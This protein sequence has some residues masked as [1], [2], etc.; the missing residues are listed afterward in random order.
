MRLALLPL[1]WMDISKSKSLF[2]TIGTSTMTLTYLDQNMSPAN[3][4]FVV[5]HL[6]AAA[7]SCPLLSCSIA[8]PLET[9]NT[10]CHLK[11]VYAQPNKA[12]WPVIR[13]SFLNLAGSAS[14]GEPKFKLTLCHI[15]VLEWLQYSCW[16]VYPSRLRFRRK[17]E[18]IDHLSWTILY[19]FPQN[20]DYD[21]SCFFGDQIQ[22]HL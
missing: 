1:H 19:L 12:F 4:F 16:N 14:N 22:V 15:K 20:V 5:Y 9:C 10:S 6:S 8:S 18:W 17:K 3:K 21:S 13:T 11:L 7:S 2:T